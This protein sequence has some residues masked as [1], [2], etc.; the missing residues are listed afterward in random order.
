MNVEVTPLPGIGVR[1]D[2]PLDR[3]RRRI[4]VIDHRDGTIDLIVSRPRHPDVTEQISLSAQEA[5]VLANLLGAPQLVSRLAEQPEVGAVSTRQLSITAGS[6]YDGR[7]LGD[8]QMRT[9]TTASIVAVMR[10]GQAIPAPGPDFT[11]TAGDVLVVV[12]TENGLAAAARILL[13]G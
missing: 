7:P 5:A 2:F 10:A 8:T 9:R 11:M 1:K 3:A 12:G 13:H 4:G 6:T